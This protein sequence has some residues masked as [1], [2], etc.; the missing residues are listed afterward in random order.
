[1]RWGIITIKI[2]K[3]RHVIP[4]IDGKGW[5]GDSQAALSDLQMRDKSVPAYRIKWLEV[6]SAR[7]RCTRLLL[8]TEMHRTNLLDSEKNSSGIEVTQLDFPL[9]QVFS[10]GTAIEFPKPVIS[11]P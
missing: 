4:E 8:G 3:A 5:A 6:E 1:M 11:L 9:K 7:F 2:D 10:Q